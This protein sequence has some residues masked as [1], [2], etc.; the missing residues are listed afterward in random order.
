MRFGA[1]LVKIWR[2]LACARFRAPEPVAL[3]RFLAERTDLILGIQTSS[4][5]LR[6]ISSKII[7]VVG[8]ALNLC[9]SKGAILYSKKHYVPA[10]FTSS[11]CKRSAITEQVL[12]VQYYTVMNSDYCLHLYHSKTHQVERFE[13]IAPDIIKM[14]VCGPTVYNL[15]HIGNAR[16]AVV[17]DTLYRLLKRHYSHVTYVRNITDIDDKIILKA[18]DENCTTEDLTARYTASYH[19]NLQELNVL[20]PDAEPR[21]TEY[22]AQM[23][24]MI[25]RLT[26]QGFAY[27]QQEHVLFDVR[28]MADYGKL[29]NRSLD[30]MQAGARVE[31]ADYKNYPLDFVLWKPSTDNQPGWDSP[32]GFGRPGW[33]LECSAMAHSLLGN[34]IDIHGGGQDLLFPHHEN[35]RAQSCCSSGEDELANYWVHNG[36]VTLSGEKMSKSLGNIFTVDELLTHF[37]GEVLRLVLL[38]THYRKPLDWSQNALE[39]A[40]ASLDSIYQMLSDTSSEAKGTAIESAVSDF[41]QCLLKDL[42]TPQ[43]LTLLRQYAKRARS[44]GAGWRATVLECGQRIGLLQRSPQN[45]FHGQ[46]ATNDIDTATIEQAIA[47]RQQAKQQRNFALADSIRDDL[48]QRGIILEDSQQGTVWKRG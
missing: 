12:L 29:S 34:R 46:R 33:H 5:L 38:S 13:P 4:T 27:V 45:W 9:Y 1:F 26:A 18:Q 7:T 42:N 15:I 11:L 19:S 16:P 24:A 21:A 22:I 14:Y 35:E 40:K 23:I 17:F 3:N 20:Q 37:D 32:W 44:E 47:Q 25:E 31:V 10:V 41:E 30:D 2:L 36:Y 28:K 6:A 39:K 43:A 48:K 8:I